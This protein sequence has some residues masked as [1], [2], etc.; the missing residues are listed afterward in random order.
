MTRD[1]VVGNTLGMIGLIALPILLG[2]TIYLDRRFGAKAIGQARQGEERGRGN[3]YGD[4]ERACRHWGI[5]P[6]QYLA[7]PGCY[8]LPDRGAGLYG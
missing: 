7:C 4:A 3:P 2:I 5:S 6:E 8:P 1:E